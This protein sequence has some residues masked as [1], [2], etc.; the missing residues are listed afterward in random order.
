M[1]AVE[2]KRCIFSFLDGR[3]F[4]VLRGVEEERFRIFLMLVAASLR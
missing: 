1:L 4:L 3:V 2:S